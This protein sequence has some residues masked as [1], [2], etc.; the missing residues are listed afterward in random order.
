MPHDEAD[1]RPL[2][3]RKARRSQGN[4]DCVE[5]AAAGGRVLVRDSKNPD[6]IVL[7]YPAG[8]WLSFV[9]SAKRGAYDLP[10][11]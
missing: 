11:S 3:W 9:A 6:G 2:N 10:Y 5:V 7:G 8:S 1:L 4:G